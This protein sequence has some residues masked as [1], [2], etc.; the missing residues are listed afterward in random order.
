MDFLRTVVLR[1]RARIRAARERRPA[2]SGPGR[3][4][5]RRP[6][7]GA[8]AGVVRSRR[9]RTPALRGSVY[10]R[11]TKKTL[12]DAISGR[13]QYFETDAMLHRGRPRELPQPSC[14]PQACVIRC[15]CKSAGRDA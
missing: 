15:L 14:G 13:Y 6:V 3:V 1:Q 11:N 8:S 12:F 10:L 9:S 4:G 5:R 2:S 7:Q